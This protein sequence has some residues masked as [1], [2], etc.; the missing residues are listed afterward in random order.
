MDVPELTIGRNSPDTEP[1]TVDLSA[2]PDPERVH[3]ARRHARLWLSKGSWWIEPLGRGPV[4]LN[5]GKPLSAP[6]DLASGDEVA[7]GNVLFLFSE[8][9]AG[10]VPARPG[11]GE[12]TK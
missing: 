2:L 11:V 6:A 1:V 10:G 3:V 12:G 8:A 4:F 7:L 9:A 5:R